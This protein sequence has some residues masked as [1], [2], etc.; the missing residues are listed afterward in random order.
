MPLASYHWARKPSTKETLSN[1]L[2]IEFSKQQQN[3]NKAQLQVKKGK[4]IQLQKNNRTIVVAY[5]I[6]QNSYTKPL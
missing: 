6:D 3:Y 5:Y 4:S 1:Q 2:I